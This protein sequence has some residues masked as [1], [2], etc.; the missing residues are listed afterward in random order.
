MGPDRLPSTA[1]SRSRNLSP[2]PLSLLTV[3]TLF[4]R[5]SLFSPYLL[6]IAPPKR[7]IYCCRQQFDVHFRSSTVSLYVFIITDH[8]LASVSLSIE[9]LPSSPCSLCSLLAICCCDCC[10]VL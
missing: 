9:A 5:L 3:H 4:P 10:A 8:L 6:S 1:S 7:H 2:P